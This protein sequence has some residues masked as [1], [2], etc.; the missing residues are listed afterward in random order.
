MVEDLLTGEL[1]EDDLQLTTAQL[2][3]SCHLSAEQ[4]FELI[5][6]GIVE[7][8]GREVAQWRFQGTSVY[9]IR[10][11]VQLQRDLGVNW[12]GAALALELLDELR[13][14][15]SRLRRFED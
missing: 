4:L 13:V 3:R 11:A 12:A 7:P 6:Q 10:C 14:L 1:L 8:Q 9:R 15:R 2:C 5:E